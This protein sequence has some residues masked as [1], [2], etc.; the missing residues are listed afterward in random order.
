MKEQHWKPIGD[1]T[2]LYARSRSIDSGSAWIASEAYR[3]YQNPAYPSAAAMIAVLLDDRGKG[4]LAEPVVSAALFE[5]SGQE[6]VAAI[7][8][9]DY[10][11]FAH[12]IGELGGEIR[13]QVKSTTRE[14]QNAAAP[15]DSARVF[16][17][18]LVDVSDSNQ[19]KRLVVD[20]L[21]GLL[22]PNPQA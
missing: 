17:Q 20:P 13:G 7:K 16:A 10:A 15:W 14:G 11:A 21:L 1:K 12:L 5:F 9:S 19:I 6:K 3:M 22:N 4:Y 2:A 18:P 8:P